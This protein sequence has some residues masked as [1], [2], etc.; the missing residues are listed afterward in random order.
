MTF[1][2]LFVFFWVGLGF[3]FRISGFWAW[4]PAL[5]HL[6]HTSSSFCSDYFGH[7]MLQTI[8]PHWPWTAILQISVSQVARVTSMNH[9]CPA[10]NDFLINTMVLPEQLNHT[11]DLWPITW[12]ELFRHTFCLI[13]KVFLYLNLKFLSVPWR[14]V[15]MAYFASFHGMPV[16]HNESLFSSFHHSS[17]LFDVLRH[18]AESDTLECL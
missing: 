5:Y 18:V 13:P 15:E 1:F 16:W 4:V 12:Q 14:W 11:F 3:E 6:N 10:N 9:Q 2:F 8:C 7:G 17:S